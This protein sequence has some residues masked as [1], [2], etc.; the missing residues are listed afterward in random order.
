MRNLLIKLRK[1]QHTLILFT[2]S[3]RERAQIILQDHKLKEL[4]DEFFYREDW[5]HLNVNPPKDLRLVNADALIDDD[6][7]TSH[8]RGRLESVVFSCGRSAADRETRA[9]SR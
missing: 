8:S 3:T 6:R 2:Q 5:D 7:N 1:D 9:R 4:F